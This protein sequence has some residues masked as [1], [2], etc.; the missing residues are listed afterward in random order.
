MASES[1][2][3]TLETLIIELIKSR[4]STTAELTA[5]LNT[6]LAPINSALESITTTMAKHT[7]TSSEMETALSTH[8]DNIVS[9]E[10]GLPEDIEGSNPRQFMADLFKEVAAEALLNSTPELDRAHRSLRPKPRQGS[11]PVIV[12]FHRFIHKERVLLWAKEHRN[13]T[14]R[15]HNIKF[16]ED[17]S[18][19]VAK[20]RAAFNQVKLPFKKGI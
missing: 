13:M 18:P 14:Y 9:L 10:P 4:K 8:S 2:S 17:F 20:R 1:S 5:F 11:C 16:Y 15:G 7:S 19:A 12:H 6:A 3:L